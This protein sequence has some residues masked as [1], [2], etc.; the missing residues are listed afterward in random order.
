MRPPTLEKI[1]DWDIIKFFIVLYWVEHV[2]LHVKS[3]IKVGIINNVCQLRVSQEPLKKDCSE[4][5]Q[6]II[7]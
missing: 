1:M 6:H 3:Y 5:M 7:I 2:S 4:K